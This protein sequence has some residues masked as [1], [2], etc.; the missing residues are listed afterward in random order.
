MT[1]QKARILCHQRHA[2]LATLTQCVND[3]VFGMAAVDRIAERHFGE[4]VNGDM[5]V[6]GFWAD[7]KVHGRHFVRVRKV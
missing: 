6:D 5:V 3:V 2:Q 7:C 1:H 4:L